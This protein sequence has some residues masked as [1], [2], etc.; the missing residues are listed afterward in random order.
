MINFLLYIYNLKQK[1]TFQ[2]YHE[3]TYEEACV[4]ITMHDLE[5]YSPEK[6][7]KKIYKYLGVEFTTL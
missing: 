2:K 6:L 1:I 7:L 3:I 4:S 5:N